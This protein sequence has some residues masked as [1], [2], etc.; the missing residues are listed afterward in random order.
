MPKAPKFW[1][2]PPGYYSVLAQPFAWMYTLAHHVKS[3]QIQGYKA[4]VPV[5]CVGNFTVGGA[6]K[7]PLVLALA[8]QLQ[9]DH[10]KIVHILMRGYGG[11]IKCTTQ[12]NLTQHSYSDVGDEALLLAQVAP[13]WVGRDRGQSA[14]AAEQ[15]GAQVLLM[16]DGAQNPSLLKDL[17]FMVIDGQKGL[18]NGL[19]LPAG[20]LREQLSQGLLR[21]DA[22]IMVGEDQ[23]SVS[24]LLHKPI[25]TAHIQPLSESIQNIKGKRLVAFA[26]IG[27]PDKFFDTLE[28]YGGKV[29]EKV[30]FPDHY[31]YS[32]R[33]LQPLVEKAKS[34]D[35][36]LVTT[37]KDFVRVPLSLQPLVTP[38]K[39]HLEF[40]N[41]D[42]ILSRL[43]PLFVT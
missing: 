20:P 43:E 9:K 16:D 4:R 18:G 41:S 27:F 15:A 42:N 33:D 25:T 30:A 5:I 17:C 19:V 3:R 35:V 36:L 7:T 32:I 26:G 11:S 8:R 39:I 31:P 14:R 22:V 29:L 21:T 28:Q 1:Y 40:K 6:G 10:N 12:V 23:R 37:E 38:F 13:T 2:Q 24:K 34:E